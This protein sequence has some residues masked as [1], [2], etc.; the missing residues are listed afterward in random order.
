MPSRVIEFD[1][2]SDDFFDDPYDTYAVLRDEAPLYFNEQYGFYALSRYADVMAA[3][4]D[5][6]FE[7]VIS[8]AKPRLVVEVGSWK[9]AS[10]AHMAKL[11]RVH[12]EPGARIICIDTWLGSPDHFLAHA[13]D[14]PPDWRLSLRLKNGYPQLYYTFLCNMVRQKVDDMVIPLPQPSLQGAFIIRSLGLRPDVVYIDADHEYDAV[15]ADLRAFWPLLSDDGILI[16][17]DFFSHSTV[18]QAAYDFSREVN[19]P[20]VG[21]YSKFVLSKSRTL[22]PRISLG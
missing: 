19:V 16:G 20:L 14:Q 8:K 7:E 21:K 4:N 10:A 3:H 2:F 13:L 22:Q 5:P 12:C 17:D 1:P 9:G 11:M 6:V 18:T 15:L